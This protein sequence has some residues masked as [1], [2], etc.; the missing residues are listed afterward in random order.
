MHKMFVNRMRV[1]LPHLNCMY[2]SK[3]TAKFRNLQFRQIFLMFDKE[4]RLPFFFFYV[5]SFYVITSHRIK[6]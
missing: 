5:N 3:K 2:D 6:T 1:P 4:T